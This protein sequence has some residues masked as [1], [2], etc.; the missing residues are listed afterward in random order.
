MIGA[1]DAFKYEETQI[2]DTQQLSSSDTRPLMFLI[3]LQSL[4]AFLWVLV[5]SHTRHGE[6][7]IFASIASFI[8]SFPFVFAVNEQQRYLFSFSVFR[9]CF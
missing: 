2:F 7:G 6:L 1:S 9:K 4:R 3:C 5:G 8:I